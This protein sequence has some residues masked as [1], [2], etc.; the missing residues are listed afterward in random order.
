M[1]KQNVK[2]KKNIKIL[3]ELSCKIGLDNKFLD[4]NKNTI[5]MRKYKN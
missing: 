5:H 2:L 3:G 4:K 1:T